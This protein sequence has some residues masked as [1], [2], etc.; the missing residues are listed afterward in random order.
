VNLTVV[1]SLLLIALGA[2]AIVRTLLLGVGGGLGLVL[3]TLLV[4]AGAAR[5][6]IARRSV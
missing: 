3:G 1:F 2:A 6:Y 5:L 4:G